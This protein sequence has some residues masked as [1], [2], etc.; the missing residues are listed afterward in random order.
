MAL[1]EWLAECP[2]ALRQFIVIAPPAA[3]IACAQELRMRSR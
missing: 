2:N 3:L 1:E